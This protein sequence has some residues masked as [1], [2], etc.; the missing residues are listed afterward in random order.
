MAFIKLYGIFYFFWFSE[1]W[2]INDWELI[3]IICL[4][5]IIRSATLSPAGT[6]QQ[7]QCLRSLDLYSVYQLCS[8]VCTGCLLI[9]N[10]IHSVDILIYN[11]VKVLSATLVNTQANECSVVVLKFGYVPTSFV[12]AVVVV[13]NLLVYKIYLRC[14]PG[15][16]DKFYHFLIWILS[17]IQLDFSDSSDK[18]LS[19]VWERLDKPITSTTAMGTLLDEQLGNLSKQCVFSSNSWI[20]SHKLNKV[21]R[22]ETFIKCYHV[23]SY[24]HRKQDF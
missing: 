20:L 21:L 13:V 10:T 18:T 6:E 14:Q 8:S 2:T 19:T 11:D 3:T 16:K 5:I 15:F 12:V 1:V 4:G 7:W 9:L 24:L 23:T 17:E 22:K